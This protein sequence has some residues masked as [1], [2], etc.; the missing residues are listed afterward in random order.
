MDVSALIDALGGTAEV[1]RLSEVRS[2]SVS[3]WRAS[4][5]IPEDR[6][7]RLSLIAEKRGVATRK[8][9]FPKDW[10]VLWPELAKAECHAKPSTKA[11]A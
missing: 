7:I 3:G 2:P 1:A 11:G 8:Q 4:G 6:L 5:R 9:L 10:Q